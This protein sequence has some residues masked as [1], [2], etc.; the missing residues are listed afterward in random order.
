MAEDSSLRNLNCF[1]MNAS[2]AR[3]NSS[4]L[5]L[6]CG[7]K[8]SCGFSSR[9]S[10]SDRRRFRLRGVFRL[11]PFQFSDLLRRYFAAGSTLGRPWTVS[12]MT[13]L[14]WNSGSGCT[15]GGGAW[16]TVTGVREL[17]KSW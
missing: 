13:C 4:L 14:S 7:Y 1:A 17:R 10:V 6:S 2:M 12:A 8:F 15:R 3:W 11:S 9:F 16:S 5:S